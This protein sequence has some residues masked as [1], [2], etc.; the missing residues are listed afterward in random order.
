MEIHKRLRG[1]VAKLNK[2]KPGWQEHI[3]INTLNMQSYKSCILGQ[4]Y[5]SYDTG[6]ATVYGS[7]W[8]TPMIFSEGQKI[9]AKYLND[10]HAEKAGQLVPT[11]NS[12]YAFVIVNGYE[13]DCED[14]DTLE[15]LKWAYDLAKIPYIVFKKV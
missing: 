9:W 4:L 11:T 6:S 1:P 7:R 2:V 10:Y 13:L 3:N 5:D 15:N 8:E 14:N 12:S